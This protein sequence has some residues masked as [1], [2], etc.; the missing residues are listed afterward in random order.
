MYRKKNK[1][2]PS[3]LSL[4]RH[5]PLLTPPPPPRP[6][7]PPSLQAYVL[8]CFPKILYFKTAVCSRSGS[9]RGEKNVKKKK[10]KEKKYDDVEG[11]EVAAGGFRK[12]RVKTLLGERVINGKIT[13]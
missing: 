13:E 4:S 1:P 2:F 11:E 12:E 10:R 7:L 3:S 5:P 9:S 6:S 8:P